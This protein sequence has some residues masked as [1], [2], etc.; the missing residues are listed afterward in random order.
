MGEKGKS[1]RQEHEAL[2]RLVP[3]RGMAD[4]AE[5]QAI[6]LLEQ[7]HAERWPTGTEAYADCRTADGAATADTVWQRLAKLVRRNR[8][9]R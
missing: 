6:V 1:F 5:Q 3:V 4:L 2:L 7:L 9:T 8:R